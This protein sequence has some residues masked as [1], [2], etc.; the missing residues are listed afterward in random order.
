MTD[1]F[2][3]NIETIRTLGF[4]QPFGSLMLPPFNKIETR[5][6]KCGKKPPF[7]LGKYLFYTTLKSADDNKLYDWC[8]D[9]IMKYLKAVIDGEPTINLNGY[10]LGIGELTKVRPMTDEDEEQAFVGNYFETGKDNW[11]LIFS[12][13]YRIEPF[14]FVDGEGNSLGKQGVGILHPKYHNLIIPIK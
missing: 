3:E 6:V 7:P 2:G 10:G 14:P 13:V 1:L 4:Y 9:V 11:C 5:K 12:N 8:G